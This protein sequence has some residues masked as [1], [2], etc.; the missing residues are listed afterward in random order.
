M[1]NV[2]ESCRMNFYVKVQ[3]QLRGVFL[4]SGS[5]L[6]HWRAGKPFLL[7]WLKFRKK[8]FLRKRL[9]IMVNPFSTMLQFCTPWKHQNL[10]DFL[11]F[12]EGYRSRTSTENGLNNCKTFKC[13]EFPLRYLV[14]FVQFKKRQKHRWRS[15]TF[16]A[17]LKVALPHGCF[18][19]F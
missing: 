4:G 5:F 1:S 6:F 13:D 11:M 2:M 10:S 12:L 16:R 7:M 8:S 19:H 15:V 17:L 3:L 9:I 18:S 14:P